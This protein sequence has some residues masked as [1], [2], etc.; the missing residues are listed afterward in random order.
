MSG[1]EIHV[2]DLPQG[3]EMD[4]GQSIETHSEHYHAQPFLEHHSDLNLDFS[5]DFRPVLITK[6]LAL[7]L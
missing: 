5:E 4:F 6:L 7:C 3:S 1:E 2:N